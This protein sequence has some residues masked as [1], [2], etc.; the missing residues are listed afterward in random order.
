MN[1]EPDLELMEEIRDATNDAIDL[2]YHANLKDAVNWGDLGVT[3]VEYCYSLV[4]GEAHY[5]ITISEASPE[6]YKFKTFIAD[7]LGR[8]FPDVSLYVETEW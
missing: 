8:R 5:I 1:F 3:D 7:E 2:S 6:A 4:C